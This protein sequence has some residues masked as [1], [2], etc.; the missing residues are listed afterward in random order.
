MRTKYLLFTLIT[1][2]TLCLNNYGQ[3][4]LEAGDVA[5]V[6][7]N[8]RGRQFAFILLKDIETNT[9]ISFTNKGWKDTGGWRVTAGGDPLNGDATVT[10]TAD[11][12]YKVGAIITINELNSINGDG[13]A[14]TGGIEGEALTFLLQGD[15][16]YC[17]Q[18]EEPVDNNDVDRFITVIG[19]NVA[20]GGFSTNGAGATNRSNGDLPSNLIYGDNVEDRN[21]VLIKPERDNA[22]YKGDIDGLEADAL[23]DNINNSENWESINGTNTDA[24]SYDLRLSGFSGDIGAPGSTGS[25]LTS[26]LNEFYNTISVN[27]NPVNDILNIEL[28]LSSKLLKASLYNVVGKEVISFKSR[29]LNMTGIPN[30]VYLLNIETDKTRIVKKIIKY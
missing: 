8:T 18:G 14:G 16:I 24:K 26:E 3:T 29:T 4:A 6:G 17:Y 28:G 11:S 1:S 19:M 20:N 22:V 30:G 9:K 7:S 27:P 21:V 13:T 2:L 23:R 12:A 10:W 25:T 5:F 15:N